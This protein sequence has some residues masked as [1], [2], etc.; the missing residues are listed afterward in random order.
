MISM[1]NYLLTHEDQELREKY[2]DYCLK[3]ILSGEEAKPF[4][5][6]QGG[7]RV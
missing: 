2:A 1:P 6:F 3:A 4:E 7:V 5:E